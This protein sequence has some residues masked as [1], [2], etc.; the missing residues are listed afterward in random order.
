MADV[1]ATVRIED[2]TDARDQFIALGVG[3]IVG[4]CGRDNCSPVWVLTPSSLS[5][6]GRE[7]VVYPARLLVLE[8]MCWEF[9]R[10]SVSPTLGL[11]HRPTMINFGRN[12]VS[13][14]YGWVGPQSTG[15][16]FA[17]TQAEVHDA[18]KLVVIDTAGRSKDLRLADWLGL[19][20][21]WCHSRRWV[22]AIKRGPPQESLTLWNLDQVERGRVTKVEGVALPWRVGRASFG[23][24]GSLVVSHSGGGVAAI[25]LAAS[26]AR[27][28]AV[29]NQVPVVPAV[30]G[31]CDMEYVACWDGRTYALIYGRDGSPWLQCLTTGQRSLLRH[32]KTQPLGGP[33]IS[34]CIFNKGERR[35]EVYSVLEP[36]KVCRVYRAQSRTQKPQASTI[37][38]MDAGT[39][40]LV[41]KMDVEAL[42]GIS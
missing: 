21:P 15:D 4:R 34:V 33:Y 30:G 16:R 6:I 13:Y 22:A 5:W 14:V 23:C 17:L 7:W 40:F 27:S 24:D 18:Q 29:W 20:G 31:T 9:V 3:V 26:F 10:F 25:D 1:A 41:F 8:S 37:E 12:P 42:L 36:T 28:K 19:N 35:L 11:V 32:T 38:V 2:E 39:G